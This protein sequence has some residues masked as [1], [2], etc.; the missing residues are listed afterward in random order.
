MARA[1]HD[2]SLAVPERAAPS[3]RQTGLPSEDRI[4]LRGHEDPAATRERVVG[5]PRASGLV[6]RRLVAGLDRIGQVRICAVVAPAGSGKTTALAHWARRSAV[7]V[8]WWRADPSPNDA[9]DELVRGIAAAVRRTDS[10]VP[11][12]PDPVLLADALAHRESDLVLVI[13]DLHHLD[14]PETGQLLEQLLL[15]SDERLHLIV[16]S[17]SHPQLNLARTELGSTVVGPAEL[18]FRTCETADLFRTVYD[19]PLGADDARHLTRHTDGWAAGLH[20]FHQATAG[21]APDAVHRA[22]RAVDEQSAFVE[23]YLAQAVLADM[24]TDEVDFLRS[25]APLETLTGPRCDRLT[26]RVDSLDLLTELHRRGVLVAA[27]DGGGLTVPR[28]LRAHLVAEL[29]EHLGPESADS[30]FADA[31]HIMADTAGPVTLARTFA[32]GRHWAAA[33]AVLEDHWEVVVD[34]RDLDWLAAAPAAVAAEP[35]VRVA[36]AERARRDGDLR[37]ASGL[38]KSGPPVPAGTPQA[39]TADAVARFARMWTVGDLQPGRSWVE[40]LRAAVRRPDPGRRTALEPPYGE[41]LRSV[42][43]AL[44]GDLRGARRTV[45]ACPGRLYADTWAWCA[46]ELLLAA[47]SPEPTERAG[48]VAARADDLGLPWLAR[49]AHALGAPSRPADAIAAE[50]GEADDRGDAWGAL[51]LI[52]IDAAARLRERRRADGV[53]EE[54]VTRCRRLDAPAFEAWA[55]SGLALCAAATRLPDAARDAES[56]VGFAHSAQV[57]GALVFARAALAVARSDADLRRLAAEEAR[58]VGLGRRWAAWIDARPDARPPVAATE[59][60]PPVAVRCFGG[61]DI[62]VEGAAPSLSGVRPRARALLR[63]LSLYA[64]Q[65]VH[66]E[67]LVDAMWPQLDIDAGTH[68]LHVCIS[69]LRTTLEPGVARGASRLILRDGD[70]YLLALPPGSTA[71]LRSFDARLA[72]AERSRASGAADDAIADLEEALR[73]YVG[74]VLPE[75]GPTDWVVPHRDHY[76][77]RAA[78]GAAL[79]GRLHLDKGRPETAARAL[80]RSIDIDP[81]RDASWRLLVAAHE[82][83]GDLAAAE[84]ARRSYADVLTT[85]GLVASTANTMRKA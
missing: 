5:I 11:V 9:V 85:L 67:V 28:T 2:Q 18:R 68:N 10:R 49:I 57:P 8:A 39:A 58:Q 4:V 24:S 52:A 80:R 36:L 41:L 31:A 38:L 50:V 81:C 78:E 71:D 29:R 84:E 12:R 33:V 48:S 64:G 74:E 14:G 55:R 73:L 23:D 69:G 65:P 22:V 26:G 32:A 72:T 6:R 70:R 44:S 35:A 7:D 51:L 54:L 21:R 46:A 76:Q 40:Y 83:A 47:L 82:A 16:C 77:V 62:R 75:D 79:L 15:A 13:D 43:L 37:T 45:A 27:E 20:L 59:R 19:A 61:F 66:R 60:T 1:T 42:E 3:P 56:A 34:N 53:F 17:Q 25:T 63:L 30:R